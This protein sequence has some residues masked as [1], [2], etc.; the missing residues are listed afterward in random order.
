MNLSYKY[1]RFYVR[2]KLEYR[3]KKHYNA[4]I[5][6]NQEQ[7]K[8]FNMVM[9]LAKKNSN[10]IKFV[11]DTQEILIVLPDMLITLKRF[12]VYV[13]IIS[14][15]FPQDIFEIMENELIKEGHRVRRKLKHDVKVR[16]NSF[17]NNVI[18][19]FDLEVPDLIPVTELSDLEVSGLDV[20]NSEESEING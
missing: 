5:K 19:T 4:L 17:L 15:P 14:T 12:R 1:K 2:K 11:L 20:P 13:D 10:D 7:L 6:L 16:I 8:V 3:A 18:E 9:S